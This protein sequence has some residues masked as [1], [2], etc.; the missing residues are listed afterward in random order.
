M[1]G[2][3][4]WLGH[5]AT[6]EA[7][8]TRL[9]R[10]AAHIGT[11]APAACSIGTHGG[12]TICGTGTP[13]HFFRNTAS[14]VCAVLLGHPH[15]HRSAPDAIRSTTTLAESFATAYHDHG[16]QAITWLGGEFALALIDERTQEVLLAIDRTGIRTLAYHTDAQGVVFSTHLG[17]LGGFDGLP[18]TLDKQALYDYLYF[19]V[20]P[21]PATIYQNIQRLLPGQYLHWRAG[22]AT[23]GNY[24]LSDYSERRPEPFAQDQERLFELLRNAVR[25]NV[26]SPNVGCFLSGGLDSSTVV[27]ITS[28]ITGTPAHSFSI[29]FAAEGYDEMEY[30]RTAARHFGAHHEIYYVTPEDVRTA[31]PRV[32]AHYDN[33]FGNASAVP[34]YYC[35]KLA[36]DQGV[37]LLLGG[38]GGDELFGGNSRYAKQWQLS[39]YHLLPSMLRQGLLEP[40]IGTVPTQD[41]A[42]LLNK[43]RS[44]IRQAKLPPYERMEGYNLLHRIGAQTLLNPDFLADVSTAHPLQHLQ[45]LYAS[46]QGRDPI[47]RMMAMDM[48]LTLADNDLIKVGGMCELAGIEVAYPF[49]DDDLCAFAYGLPLSMK[50]RRTQLRHFYKNAMRGFLPD[51]IIDKKK[52]GFGLPFGVWMQSDTGLRDLT[53]DS[54]NA[55]KSRDIVSSAFIDALINTHI[56]KHPGYYGTLA[57]VLMMLEHWFETHHA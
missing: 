12:L 13:L 8:Q 1:N 4:G 55:L 39:L 34:L 41:G 28:E 49:L 42:G 29:G 46:T 48:Q 5:D 6:Q 19:H 38:D 36:R 32:A 53:Y 37:A 3:C 10:M 15:W 30:A 26:G 9:T 50:L 56:P 43:L 47:T 54:L 24:A 35:A 22:Q 33:P 44:Y 20:I 31:V 7:Q 52:H 40:L 23:L 14:G 16:A 45:L 11:I 2:F 57:W 18:R 51:A 27:G 25:N 21:A 17:A